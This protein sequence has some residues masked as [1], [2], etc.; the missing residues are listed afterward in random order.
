MNTP[1][2]ICSPKCWRS[3]PFLSISLFRVH[4]QKERGKQYKDPILFILPALHSC[5]PLHSC[6]LSTPL[7]SKALYLTSVAR[8]FV[9][10]K[11]QVLFRTTPTHLEIV[12]T[13]CYR[14]PVHIPLYITSSYTPILRLEHL[15]GWCIRV[16][17]KCY[18]VPL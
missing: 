16:H 8:D 2:E 18:Q 11:P 3:V 13:W 12:I 5:L 10:L 7:P 1:I 17:Y 15:A 14:K 9:E 6:L 4:T